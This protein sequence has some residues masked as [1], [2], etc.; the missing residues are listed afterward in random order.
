MGLAQNLYSGANLF[1]HRPTERSG[2]EFVDR[3]GFTTRHIKGLGTHLAMAVTLTDSSK[4]TCNFKLQ[5]QKL[6]EEAET[7]CKI[8]FPF[9]WRGSS[10]AHLWQKIP[11]RSI[12]GS[13]LSA[14]SFRSVRPSSFK[15]LLIV[16][17]AGASL[18]NS[19]RASSSSFTIRGV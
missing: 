18:S 15:H 5:L 6:G 11:L 19:F 16:R 2:T 13:C 14:I 3:L 1:F 8:A 12:Q 7:A 17:R 4:N 10:C 9:P